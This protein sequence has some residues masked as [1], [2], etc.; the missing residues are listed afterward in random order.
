MNNNYQQNASAHPGVVYPAREAESHYAT[1]DDLAGEY[2]ILTSQRKLMSRVYLWLMIALA[3][4]GASAYGIAEVPA[5]NE[6]INGNP[7]FRIGLWIATMA[8]IFGLSFKLHAIP[9]GLGKIL[10]MVVALMFGGMVSSI[11]SYYALGS[12]F[13]SLF[14]TAGAFAGLSIYGF[15]TKKN[16]NG[17]G[18]FCFFA[19]WGVF[20]ALPLNIFLFQSAVLHN[21]IAVAGVLVIG[22]MTAWDTQWI[23]Q[24]ANAIGPMDGSP[25]TEEAYNRA[26]TQGSLHLFVNFY[27]MFMFILMLVGGRE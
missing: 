6:T 21:V 4:C 19:F 17:I 27:N 9:A 2:A 24:Q 18:V 12:I 7:I 10:L 13:I 3:V 22:G 11:L 5:L 26:A 23:K 1:D 25:R 14:A 16:L 20:I 15:T 8:M